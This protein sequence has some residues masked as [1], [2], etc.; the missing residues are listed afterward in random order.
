MVN[1]YVLTDKGETALQES[2]YATLVSRYMQ[3][4]PGMTKETAVAEVN[5]DLAI[6]KAES[7]GE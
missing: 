2:I 3:N 4:N 1:R 5:A 6:A 7:D